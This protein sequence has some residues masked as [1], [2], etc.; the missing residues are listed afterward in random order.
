MILVFIR[1]F[2]FFL[3]SSSR[4]SSILSQPRSSL[5]AAVGDNYPNHAL[6]S[7]ST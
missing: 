4:L 1:A 5:G 7:P 6:K 3:C 2:I